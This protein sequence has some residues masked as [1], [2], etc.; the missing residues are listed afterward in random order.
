VDSQADDLD[1]A[2]R[3][4]T[5]DWVG[6][7]ADAY[8]RWT[9]LQ[10]DAVR[11]LAAAARTMAA[12]TEGAAA[13]V[14]GVRVM[15]RDAIAVLVS[16]LIDYAAEEAFSLGIATP[17]VLEQVSTLCAAWAARIGTWLRGLISS[18]RRLHGLAGEIGDAIEALK[19]LLSRLRRGEEEAGLNRRGAKRG[20]GAI[21]YFTMD[22][23]RSIA[24]K[25]GIDISDLTI[26]LGDVKYRGVCGETRENGDIILYA[27]G[28]RSEEDLARTLEHE[29]L[30]HDDLA[31]GMTYPATAAEFDR[32]EDRA[33]AHEDDWW[34]GQPV[35]P[36]PR[37]K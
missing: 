26:T 20:A 21:Q 37:R 14:A 8:R 7:A 3:F 5:A 23:V 17:L 33:Y 13:L 36:E 1:R 27:P 10:R 16:R 25:Y 34:D 12:I 19:K 30:H 32:W 22:S 2:V 29:R 9:G 15:V 31:A 4:D 24:A 18:L 6:G 11:G 35:R 28:F